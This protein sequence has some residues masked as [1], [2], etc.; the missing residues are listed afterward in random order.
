MPNIMT[1]RLLDNI[2]QTLTNPVVRFSGSIIESVQ[3]ILSGEN[4]GWVADKDH[5]N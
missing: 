4:A 2:Q 1:M 3:K 5:G